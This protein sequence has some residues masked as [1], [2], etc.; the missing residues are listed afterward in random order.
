MIRGPCPTEVVTHFFSHFFFVASM[1]LIP[2]HSESFV[3]HLPQRK[4]KC[5]ELLSEKP[6]LIIYPR[7]F[8]PKRYEFAPRR[9]FLFL[10][11]KF[12]LL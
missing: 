2:N 12:P 5:V 1:S 7:I 9:H 4:I 6:V 10:L 8:S 3:T 11:H